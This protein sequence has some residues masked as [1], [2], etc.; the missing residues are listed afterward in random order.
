MQLHLK[1]F[2]L[3]VTRTAT[4]YQLGEFTAETR[5]LWIVCH[6]YGQRA[7]FFLRHF[8]VL[9]TGKNVIIAPEGLSK[10]YREGFSGHVG[11]SWMTKYQRE[12]EIQDYITY[13]NQLLETLQPQFQEGLKINLLGFSQGGATVCRWLPAAN[14]TFDRLILWAAAFP[15]DMNFELS[16]EKLEK[17]N[18][19]LVSG[20]E[21]ELI[22][23][24]MPNRQYDLLRSYGLTPQLVSF[25]GGHTLDAETLRQLDA[26]VI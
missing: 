9:D 16:K 5:T 24:E 3:P 26:G 11:A 13:L 17:T 18:L 21:D 22:A 10:F 4:V 1:E 20:T 2:H 12:T 8:Q 15:E 14:V 6:G 7:D 19:V 23:R 25:A